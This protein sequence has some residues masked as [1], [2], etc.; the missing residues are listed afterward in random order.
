MAITIETL[1]GCEG[2]IECPLEYSYNNAYGRSDN[3]KKLRADAK[4]DGW[5]YRKGHDYCQICAIRLGYKS[6]PLSDENY[7]KLLERS[8]TTN[9]ITQEIREKMVIALR[10][11]CFKKR[12]D[13]A[14]LIMDLRNGGMS[15]EK[16]DKHLDEAGIPTL[17][18]AS[19]KWFPMIVRTIYLEAKA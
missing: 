7:E 8:K 14:D 3:A 13:V 5:V 12:A 6:K 19:K 16:I 9:L 4:L 18:K 11:T 2:G 1:L 17:R 15:Y 10:E